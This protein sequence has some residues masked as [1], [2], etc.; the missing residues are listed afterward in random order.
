MLNTQCMWWWVVVVWGALAFKLIT[1]LPK[2]RK[3]P[4]DGALSVQG[5][6]VPHV[7]ETGRPYDLPHVAILL[8]IFHLQNL[9]H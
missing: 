9:L 5:D 3:K 7:E 1:N 4:R 8:T 2:G 6:D